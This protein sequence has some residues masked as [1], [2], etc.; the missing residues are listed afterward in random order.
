M[1]GLPAPLFGAGDDRPGG[2]GLKPHPLGAVPPVQPPDFVVVPLDIGGDPV[3]V[4]PAAERLLPVGH[5]DAGDFAVVPQRED[6]PDPFQR[7]V[8]AAADGD[9]IQFPE[10]FSGI[11]AV[12]VLR[13][14]VF[15][16][17]KADLIVKVEGVPGDAG[18]P[19]DLPDPV[20]PVLHHPS[21]PAVIEKARAAACSAH[22]PKSENSCI[23]TGLGPADSSANRL[24]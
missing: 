23:S 20:E 18:D 11:V 21:P 14:D 13:P 12:A 1:V 24:R 16:G 6:L 19:T 10:V 9:D 8:K 15:R 17:Q 5:Q 4:I 2:E 22:R 7:Q 3:V